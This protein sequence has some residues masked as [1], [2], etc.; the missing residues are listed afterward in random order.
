MEAMKGKLKIYLNEGGKG[1]GEVDRKSETG[2]KNDKIILA[3]TRQDGLE[4]WSKV[5][6]EAEKLGI[7]LEKKREWEAQNPIFWE[8]LLYKVTQKEN[9]NY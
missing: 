5:V 7:E 3:L 2:I 9:D 8:R 4:V 1:C 6:L